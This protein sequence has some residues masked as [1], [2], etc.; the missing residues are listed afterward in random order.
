MEV[1]IRE[2]KKALEKRL[3]IVNNWLEILKRQESFSPSLF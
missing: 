1:E 2:M 3:E